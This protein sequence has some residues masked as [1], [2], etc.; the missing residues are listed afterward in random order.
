MAARGVRRVAVSVVA[1]LLGFAVAPGVAQA[2]PPVP[3]YFPPAPGQGGQYPGSYLYP[4][5]LIPVSGPAT[6]DARG[7]RATDNADSAMTA[8]GLPG[9]ELGLTPNKGNVLG[10]GSSMKY[11]I[12][13]GPAPV[14]TVQPG[15]SPAAG[16]VEPTV[17]DPGGA[18]PTN[19]VGGLESA[20]STTVPAVPGNAQVLEDPAGNNPAAAAAAAA[21]ATPTPSPAPATPT[22]QVWPQTPGFAPG[23]YGTGTGP[24]ISAGQ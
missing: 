12:S 5:N 15:I 2:N 3:P 9:S 16:V 6:T 20:Q 7:I 22:P 24:N 13:A 4:Y 17:E 19:G 23:A 8:D 21:S 1:G 11:H 14:P 18:P 10:A